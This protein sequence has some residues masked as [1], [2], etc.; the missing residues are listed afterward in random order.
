MTPN[1]FDSQTSPGGTPE[2]DAGERDPPPTDLLDSGGI[3]NDDGIT[4]STPR[5]QIPHAANN[6]SAF[7]GMLL[8]ACSA[9]FRRGYGIK[10]FGRPGVNVITEEH[11][12][13]LTFGNESFALGPLRRRL[14]AIGNVD[15]GVPFHGE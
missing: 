3:D 10:G 15:D 8:I 14:I 1:S 6:K 2:P 7:R 4:N 9:N 12:G 11:S 5:K 13:K